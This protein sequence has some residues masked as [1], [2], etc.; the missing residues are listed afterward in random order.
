MAPA[1]PSAITPV[2]Q[3]PVAPHSAGSGGV[4][5]EPA[6]AKLPQTMYPGM[7]NPARQRSLAELANEQLN[8]GQRRDRYAEGVAGAAKP[9]C[10]GPNA[11]GNLLGL[12]TI[13][14]A[15]ARDKCK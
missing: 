6:A 15:A 1:R 4:Q 3:A 8:G 2:E 13:P 5:P 10:V 14:I 12:I 7:Y 11:S 9:D